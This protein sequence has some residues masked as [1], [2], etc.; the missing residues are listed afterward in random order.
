MRRVLI[1]TVAAVAGLTGCGGG[2]GD[3]LAVDRSG[4]VPGA[5]LRMVIN[6]GGT[7]T[8]NGGE[9]IRLPEKL[10]LDARETERELEVPAEDE[11]QLEPGPGS[12]LRYAVSTPTGDVRFADTSRGKP[13]AFDQVAF[14]VRRIAQDVCGLKR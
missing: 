10:L 12:V 14:L 7:V 13:A 1:V 4:D 9:S 11:L 2:A 5:K 6:D 8:C 3:L